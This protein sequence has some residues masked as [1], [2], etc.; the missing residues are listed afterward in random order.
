MKEKLPPI[1]YTYVS[2]GELSG[3]GEI[4]V[5]GIFGEAEAEVI[6]F[7]RQVQA[8]LEQGCRQLTVRVNS[9][10]G[11]LFTAF[12][13]YDTLR[14]ARDAGCTVTAEVH[15]VAASAATVFLCAAERVLMSESSQLML[16]APSTCVWGKLDELQEQVDS[17]RDSWQR[18]CSLY[19][20]RMGIP[21]EELAATLQ[22][23]TWYTAAEAINA[24][25]ADGIV[26]ALALADGA[27]KQPGGLMQAAADIARRTGA[28]LTRKRAAQA[29]EQQSDP[30]ATTQQV[31][32]Q[33]I[34]M[35]TEQMEEL[36]GALATSEQELAEAQAEAAA[37][38]TRAAAAEERA[39]KAV[40]EVEQ[41]RAAAA[42]EQAKISARIE[43]AV[44]E[45][46]AAAPLP[47]APAPAEPAAPRLLADAEVTALINSARTG[48]LI[49]YS[50]TSRD[51]WAQVNRL[52]ASEKMR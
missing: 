5:V 17:L 30:A 28:W 22:K 41:V 15:G 10:G 26:P 6:D 11:C 37:A 43:Q 25:L 24:K 4:D 1:R 27:E 18:M 29:E 3:H 46:L 19:S 33:R 45:R 31:M 34:A 14:S 32:Q 9:L 42:A 50:A 36:R 49:E 7:R 44:A 8:M 21:A 40:A 12:A 13:M 23:D 52:L 48:K 51:A 35:Q 38:A 20:E 16:H 47:S 39:D 2:T